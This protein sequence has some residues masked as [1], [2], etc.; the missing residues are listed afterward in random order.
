[1]NKSL[2]IN[3]LITLTLKS[4]ALHYLKRS[5]PFTTA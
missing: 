3:R 1:L 2:E 5:V 4:T